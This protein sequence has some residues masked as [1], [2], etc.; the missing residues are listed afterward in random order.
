MS[1][2]D[3][4]RSAALPIGAFLAVGGGAAIGAWLRWGIGIWLNQRW[5]QLPPGTLLVNV[6]GGLLMGLVLAGFDAH[7]QGSPHSRLFLI[8]GL[9]G[10]FTTFSAF[11]AESLALLLRQQY[12]WAVLH[13]GGHVLGALLATAGGFALGRFLNG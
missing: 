4:S 7:P 2:S 5:P 3:G 8:T 12:G 11:S 6:L 10:G 1:L 9:L 13:A